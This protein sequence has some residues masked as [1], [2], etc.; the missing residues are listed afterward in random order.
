MG[1]DLIFIFTT[2]YDF[3]AAATSAAV[4]FDAAATYAAA[5][6]YAIR[7]INLKFHSSHGHSKFAELVKSKLDTITA[8]SNV[9]TLIFHI[10]FGSLSR[11]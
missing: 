7:E 10:V 4:T 1:R 3:D 11:I 6:A 2:F 8:Q 9:N 5:Y